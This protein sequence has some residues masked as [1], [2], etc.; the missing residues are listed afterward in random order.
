[1]SGKHNIN[2]A[3]DPLPRALK[4]RSEISMILRAAG[5]WTSAATLAKLA[6]TGGGPEYIKYGR[7]VMYDPE[8]ALKWAQARSSI[9]KSTSDRGKSLQ[10]SISAMP[11]SA[12]GSLP[13]ASATEPK[14]PTRYSTEG[15]E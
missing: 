6:V 7:R 5:F 8:T 9:H 10:A 14:A 4:S 15:W 3:K 2:G 11:G 1:M 12:A 13:E